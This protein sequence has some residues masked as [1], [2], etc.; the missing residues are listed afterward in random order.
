[1]QPTIPLQS[2]QR[3]A[4]RR[5]LRA[6]ARGYLPPLDSPGFTSWPVMRRDLLT[7][8]LLGDIAAI[9]TPALLRA[10][11]NPVGALMTAGAGFT[12]MVLAWTLGAMRVDVVDQ[13]RS[14][15]GHLLTA[16]AVIAP[17]AVL[18][19]QA[20][21]PASSII[22]VLVLLV[23]QAMLAIVNRS[24]ES[25]WLRRCRMD[26]HGLRRT[27]IVMGTGAEVI[28]RQLHRHPGDGFLV[29]GYLSATTSRSPS[30]APLG[31][32]DSIRHTV[33]SEHIDVVMTLG[34]VTP[35]SLVSIMR[36]LEAT[37]ARLVVAP[38]LQD[39]VPGRMRGLPVTH[40]WSGLIDVR[41]RRVRLVTKDIADRV[42]AALL[43]VIA[44]PVLLAA[45]AAVRLDSPG[46]AFYTQVRVGERGRHF[47]MF[48]LRSMYVDA[49]ARRAAVVAAGGDAGN[50]VLFKDRQDPR[51]TRVGRVLRR[52][53]LDELPQ[54]LNVLRGDMSLVGPR[55]ALPQEVAEY[56]AEARRRL[57]VKPGLTG[58]WQVSGRSDLSWDSTVALDR[59]YVE[60]R[61]GQLDVEI[62][63]STLKAVV[64]GRGAY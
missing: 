4:S 31:D 9:I 8:L 21:M 37:S 48:K 34:G 45:A 51:I 35:D 53:S 17:V 43:L 15:W 59:H 1:M 32:A 5:P 29:V 24:I 25:A 44:G 26:G 2:Q 61:G 12:M 50:K 27:L 33:H 46:P 64:G 47:T 52:T 30:A 28:L 58:L 23:A 3:S 41:L 63:A 14:G 6:G 20:L 42:A 38:G 10:A 49:D 18:A 57:L 7:W 54:L 62:L 22:T 11:V 36:A 19:S 13:A 16:T 60:N 55:P 56:D 39:V 40:G